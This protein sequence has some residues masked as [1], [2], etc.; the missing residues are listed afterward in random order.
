MSA[1]TIN[2]NSARPL[3]GS[4]AVAGELDRE[5]LLDRLMHLRAILP[6]FAEELASSRRQAAVLRVENRGLLAEVR[7]LQRQSAT[8]VLPPT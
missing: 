8:D 4:R 3:S 7:R 1:T 5:H 6:V 2:A